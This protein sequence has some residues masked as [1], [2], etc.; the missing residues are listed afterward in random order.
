MQL[1]GR[2]GESVIRI[3]ASRPSVHATYFEARNEK[4]FP[5]RIVDT[6]GLANVITSIKHGRTILHIAAALNI[7]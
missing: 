3:V 1:L 5:W 4:R 2:N 7:S 6:N